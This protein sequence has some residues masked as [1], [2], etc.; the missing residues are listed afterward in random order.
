MSHAQTTLDRIRRIKE[1]AKGV[2]DY[3]V[4]GR[5]YEGA[6]DDLER[7]TRFDLGQEK[8]PVALGRTEAGKAG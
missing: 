7:W 3:E 1:A 5:Y 4:L 8:A 2:T 6:L